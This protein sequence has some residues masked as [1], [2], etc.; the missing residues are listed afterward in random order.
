[1]LREHAEDKK[2]TRFQV[3]DTLFAR[4]S[5]TVLFPEALWLVPLMVTIALQLVRANKETWEQNFKVLTYFWSPG[6]TWKGYSLS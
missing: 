1:M 6:T 5:Q 3:V 4:C 2:T